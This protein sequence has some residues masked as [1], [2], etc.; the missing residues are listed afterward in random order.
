MTRINTSK[1][2]I[3]VHEARKGKEEHN[4]YKRRG[5]IPRFIFSDLA[6]RINDY[7]SVSTNTE[8]K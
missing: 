1:L 2:G 3:K 8:E 4:G 6:V 5:S 7:N